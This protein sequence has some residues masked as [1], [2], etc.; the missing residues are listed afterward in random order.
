LEGASLIS[1]NYTHGPL[2]ASLAHLAHPADRRRA[3]PALGPG[4]PGYTDRVSTGAYEELDHTADWALRVCGKDACDLLLNACAGM[5]RLAGI[6]L[7]E[8]PAAQQELTLRGVDREAMLV[9]W[10]EEV[11]FLAEARHL[12]VSHAEFMGDPFPVLRARL[13]LVPIG[14]VERSIKAVTYH[15]LTIRE[16]DDGW[17][18]TIIFDV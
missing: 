8:A 3:A 7:E 4:R 12:A 18:A 1:F 6:T 17:E 13:S 5:Y 11:L 16:I 9:A 10:L 2:R 15:G 14:R